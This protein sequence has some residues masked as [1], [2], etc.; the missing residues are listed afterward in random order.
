M[1]LLLYSLFSTKKELIKILEQYKTQINNT[2]RIEV[3]SHT[4]Y[5]NLRIIDSINRVPLLIDTAIELGYKGISITDHE[6]ISSHMNAIDYIE[7]KREKGEVPEDF[8]LV[9]GNEIYLV[10][11]LEEVREGYKSGETKFPHFIL[12]AKD[13]KGHK[14]LRELSTVAWS[15]SFYTGKMERV[16]IT[17]QQVAD[18]LKDNKGHL[19]AG[20]AC[21][22]SEFSQNVLK[23]IEME[24][25]GM[26]EDKIQ[27]VK[28]NI[29][30][31]IMWIKEVFGED[32][33]FI[34]ISPAIYSEQIEYNMKAIHIAKSYG[35][36]FVVGT[37]AHYPTKKYRLVHKEYLNSKEGE[38]EVDDF[39]KYAHLMDNYNV[40]QNLR[41]LEHEDVIQAMQ[42]SMDVVYNQVEEYK[43]DN[44]IQVPKM[45]LP[46]F[47][48]K[49]LLHWAYDECEYVSKFAHSDNEQDRYYLYQ[50]EL[51]LLR[52]ENFEV[53][54]TEERWKRV[55]RLD[56]EMKELWLI[57]DSINTKLSSYYITTQKIIEIMWD[58]GDSLV[59]VSRGSA[60]GWYGAYLLG[61]VQMN[62]LDYNLPHFRHVHH[63][64]PEL[65][66][67]FIVAYGSNIIWKTQ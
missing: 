56:E 55:Q 63:S 22:G 17:K 65:P 38:R 19:I 2:E 31:L 59:G 54:S 41:Y 67:Y 50:C 62:P 48:V 27:E 24:K 15:Q 21:L 25:E 57:T 32:N 45:E 61:I 49:H 37:D 28:I 6:S 13:R 3:H 14:L 30:H 16:P 18:I 53:L 34:E 10:D 39:Y 51:G 11:S 58:K 4:D 43:L 64:R 40:Y 26:S 52:Y 29:H 42:S 1:I 5:S 8:K 60:G 20:T 46:D 66:D 33:M 9:L 47:E 12:L 7:E 35:L 23:W 44:P 36:P